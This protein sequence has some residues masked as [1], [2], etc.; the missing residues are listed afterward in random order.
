MSFI[1]LPTNQDPLLISH[2]VFTIYITLYIFLL[3]PDANNK[4]PDDLTKSATIDVED[5][6]A[7]TGD[8]SK[9]ILFQV[10]QSLL[11][12]WGADSLGVLLED[13]MQEL[14]TGVTTQ[15]YLY[16]TPTSSDQPHLFMVT[17]YSYLT[18]TFSVDLTYYPHSVWTHSHPSSLLL[19]SFPFHSRA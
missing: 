16:F 8:I 7:K 4:P 19:T 13:T 9:G 11:K 10:C 3:F 6:L 17:T 1:S 5:I 14:L 18:K 2:Y 12:E 15:N